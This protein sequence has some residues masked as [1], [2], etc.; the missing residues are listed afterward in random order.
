M[1]C[2]VLWYLCDDQGMQRQHRGFRLGSR[3]PKRPLVT[4]TGTGGT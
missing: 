1:L 3:P 2:M 4:D